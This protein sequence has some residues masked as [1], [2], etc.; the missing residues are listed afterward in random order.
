M[1]GFSANCFG[2][3]GK[4]IRVLKKGDFNLEGQVE[5]DETKIGGLEKN[6]YSK[7]KLEASRG[8]IGK[9]VVVGAK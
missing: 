3:E 5:V 1:V 6:K 9:A 2:F 4:E 7:D 8:T